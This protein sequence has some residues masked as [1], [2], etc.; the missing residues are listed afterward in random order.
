MPRGNFIKG[1][2]PAETFR[3]LRG[4]TSGTMAR[5]GAHRMTLYKPATAYSDAIKRPLCP[6][7]GAQMML[8]R[9]EPDSPG[10][11]RHTFECPGCDNEV[12]ETV[13]IK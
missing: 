7:C 11:E 12:T 8:T 2:Y 3:R 1:I 6:K 10:R 4:C 9:I 5:G 13:E